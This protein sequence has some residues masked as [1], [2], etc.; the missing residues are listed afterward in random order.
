ME[1][2]VDVGGATSRR[3]A[4]SRRT[5]R[6]GTI[7]IDAIFS[8]VRKVNYTVTNARV[9]Q[10]TDYDRLT[11]EVWTDGRVRPEDAVAYAAKILKDQLTIFINFEEEAETPRTPAWTRGAGCQRE[12][13]PAGRGARALGALRQLPEERQ[14]PA[15]S[16]SWCRRPRRD[17]Q[18]QELRPQVA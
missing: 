17:A 11:L 12:P 15:T 4:T 5:P 7:P 14:H 10:R 2:T 9:G 6:S 1:L 8:P 18:D 16:A 13:L 3:S